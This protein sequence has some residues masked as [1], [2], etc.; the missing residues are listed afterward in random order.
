ML[1]L[2]H[3]VLALALSTRRTPPPAACMPE[4]VHVAY[5]RSEDAYLWEHRHEPLE[6]I[7]ETLGR[8]AKSCAARLDRLRKKAV[9]KRKRAER[10]AQAKLAKQAK[11]QAAKQAKQAELQ[12]APSPGGKENE[13]AAPVSITDAGNI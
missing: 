2:R 5:S 6:E 9:A 11:L 4:N 12:A 13:Q 1:W 10:K 3:A 8:G 7:A